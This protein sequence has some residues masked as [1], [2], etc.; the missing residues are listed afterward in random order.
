MLRARVAAGEEDAPPKKVRVGLAK[1]LFRDAPEPV[2]QIV[3]RPFKTFLETQTGSSGELVVS[4]DFETLGQQLK[5]DQVQIG[6]FHGYEFAWAKQKNPQLKAIVLA[7]NENPIQRACLVVRTN[8][9]AETYADLKGQTLAYPSLNRPHCKLFLD[10]R[11][12]KSGTAADKFYGEVTAPVDSEDALDNVADGT[13]QAAIV[14]ATALDA[15]KVNKPGRAKLL[16]ALLQ[17]EAF[18]SAVIA[19]NPAAANPA[20]TAAALERFRAGLL[21]ARK[22][23][24]GKKLLQ[25]CRITSFEELPADYEQVFTDIAKAY[26]SPAAK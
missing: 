23:A 10:N 5:D 17:S 21:G 4:P 24:D 6:V 14:D 18:P 9:K 11:C 15:Y 7:V 8:C 16:K 22:T 12:V 19:Y 3:M 2:V 1:S 26:P 20:V 25:M 13:V